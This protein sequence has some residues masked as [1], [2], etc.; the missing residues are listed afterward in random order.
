MPPVRFELTTPSL[1]DQCSTTELQRHRQ[2]HVLYIFY[3]NFKFIAIYNTL[4]VMLHSLTLIFNVF[5][6][7]AKSEKWRFSNTIVTGFS[8]L[9]KTKWGMVGKLFPSLIHI[10]F[11]FFHICNRLA[12]ALMR[13]RVPLKT[14][15]L[16]ALEQPPWKYFFPHF[17]ALSHR[18]GLKLS[19]QTDF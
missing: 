19:P 8:Q 2:S 4:A 13:T 16:W 1:R 6:N 3:D 12:V 10:C 17:L 9:K 7:F 15:Q 14:T 18:K 11:H 5:V